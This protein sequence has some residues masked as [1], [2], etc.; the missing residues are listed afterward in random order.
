[1]LQ[2]C[3]AATADGS[4]IGNRT[5]I[6]GLL[7]CVNGNGITASVETEDPSE[8]SCLLSNKD[9]DWG[10]DGVGRRNVDGE[11]ECAR[12]RLSLGSSTVRVFRLVCL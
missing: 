5:G 11:V 9:V 12:M 8:V 2:G 1:M 3:G 7:V 6:E 10:G 4:D